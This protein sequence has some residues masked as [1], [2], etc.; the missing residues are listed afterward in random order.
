[1]IT[2]Y[3]IGEKYLDIETGLVTS[4]KGMDNAAASI[5][6]LDLIGTNLIAGHEIF[7]GYGERTFCSTAT[8]GDD[9]WQG[10]ATTLP[11]PNQSTGEQ[12]TVVSTSAQDGVAGTGVLTLHVHG[13][14]AT[15]VPVSETVTMNGV[16]P[17]ST[18]RTNWRFIQYI[19]TETVGSSAH[20][21]GTITLYKA[22]APA[23]IY[24]TLL[25]NNNQSLN[26]ARMVPAGKT[27]YVKTIAASAASNKPVSVRLRATSTFEETVTTG[28]FFLHKDTYFLQDSTVV[29][30]FSVPK[31]FP[32]LSIVK[33]TVYSATAGGDVSINYHGWIE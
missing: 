1:M 5:N 12:M 27:L 16:T 20:T 2:E 6:Y 4:I 10:T 25:P 11:I 32:S 8:L 28:Y 33:A 30:H 23:T 22:G 9:V 17:V 26:S 15:G 7:E 3:P 14:D 31:K 29:E 19:H 24:Q 13:L 18:I 21:V